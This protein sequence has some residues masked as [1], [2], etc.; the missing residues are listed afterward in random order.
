LTSSA[1]Q[2]FKVDE[3]LAADSEKRPKLLF[4]IVDDQLPFDLSSDNPEHRATLTD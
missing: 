3:A 4:I 2:K 1:T